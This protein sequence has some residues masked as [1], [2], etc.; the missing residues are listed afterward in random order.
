MS[1][2]PKR[3]NSRTCHDLPHPKGGR[4]SCP[5]TGDYDDCARISGSL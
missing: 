1:K 2:D 4:D 5:L 3:R